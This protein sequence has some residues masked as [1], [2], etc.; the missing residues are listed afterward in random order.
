MA[1]NSD[2]ET[3]L[4]PLRLRYKNEPHNQKLILKLVDAIKSGTGKQCQHY[5]LGY[6]HPE[7]QC[8][9]IADPDRHFCRPCGDE[10]WK[11]ADQKNQSLESKI[12]QMRQWAGAPQWRIEG[13]AD[14]ESWRIYHDA[15][16][17]FGLTKPDKPSQPHTDIK[18]SQKSQDTQSGLF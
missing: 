11:T 18:T 15:R 2:I 1:Q 5:S 10:Y 13:F 4:K 6:G 16:E 3:I 7:S 14:E 8:L 17:A 9:N 12:K